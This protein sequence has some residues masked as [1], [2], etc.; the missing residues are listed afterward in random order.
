MDKVL[1][2]V[3]RIHNPLLPGSAL[4]LL[5]ERLLVRWPVRVPVPAIGAPFSGTVV[6]VPRHLREAVLTLLFDPSSLARCDA[7]K[8]IAEQ[9]KDRRCILGRIYSKSYV[10]ELLRGA[11]RVEPELREQIQ[12]AGG[13]VPIRRLTRAAY[14]PTLAHQ[15][16]RTES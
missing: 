2:C 4:L 3:Q 15:F 1:P 9:P 11:N 5:P 8:R 14:A 13:G 7:A 12:A 16:R 10:K 6:H